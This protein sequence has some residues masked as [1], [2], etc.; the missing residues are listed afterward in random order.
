[1][2]NP[3]RLRFYLAA[4]ILLL[5]FSCDR[6]EP[7]L[8]KQGRATFSFSQQG[9]SNGRTSTAGQPAFILLNVEDASGRLVLENKKL[10]LVE[11]GSGYI[12]ES[13]VL[14]TGSHRLLAFVVLDEDSKAIYATP[15][16]GS[17]KAHLVDNALP[18]HFLVSEDQSSTVTPQV[19]AVNET[20]S[21]E[22][23]GYV[24]FNFDVVG[25]PATMDVRVKVELKIG[26]VMYLDVNSTVVVSGFDVDNVKQW[27]QEYAYS[28]FFGNDLTVKT[29]YH[30]YSFEV[31]QWGASAK[32]VVN[33]EYLLAA[34]QQEVPTTFVL[35]GSA[36]A[37]KLSHYITYKKVK[38]G[39]GY[40]W[41]PQD[42]RRY[43][44]NAVGKLERMTVSTYVDSAGSFVPLRY[45]VFS[46]TGNNMTKISGYHSENDQLYL[47]ERYEYLADGNVMSITQDYIDGSNIDWVA[48]FSYNYTG[49]VISAS[50]SAANGGG[51]QYE[52]ILPYGNVLTDRV[53]RGGQVCSIGNYQYDKGINPFKHLG[54]M[55][56]LFRNY[57]LYNRVS[58]DVQ[59][60][61]C[62]FPT[63]IPETYVFEYNALGYPTASNT[64][65]KGGNYET[66]TAY[67]YH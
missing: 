4:F 6:E 27:S 67:F 30:H 8:K 34:S 62:S 37:R 50:Y 12:T 22:E 44:Y 53:N 14:E 16:E 49:R 32:H 20:D 31:Q 26:D 46:Y 33:G 43:E 29:G 56:F 40:Y 10:S 13:L 59:Y 45:F 18:I 39:D 64:L 35:S 24:N 25:T 23:F 5:A 61:G 36:P 19:V 42:K 47:E 66:R 65:Y 52:L 41:D 2:N 1:M 15:K 57:S 17:E 55:D 38:E 51:F 7:V 21:P 28:G 3:H 48:N 58:E 63:L 9:L 60:L 11:F 54:Y